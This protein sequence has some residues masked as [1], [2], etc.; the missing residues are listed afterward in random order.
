MSS[1]LTGEDLFT[2]VSLCMPKW[3]SDPRTPSNLLW[4][5]ICV[6]YGNQEHSYHWGNQGN[7]HGKVFRSPGWKKPECQALFMLLCRHS[8]KHNSL[9]LVY[10]ASACCNSNQVQS[11]DLILLKIRHTL[12]EQSVLLIEQSSTLIKQSQRRYLVAVFDDIFCQ[13][14]HQIQSQETEF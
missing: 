9:L 13:I 1:I 8:F 14:Y 11:S 5:A 6:C 2:A 10:Q 4:Y 7:C 12:I 3:V